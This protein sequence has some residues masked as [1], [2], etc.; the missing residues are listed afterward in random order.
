V[1]SMTPTPSRRTSQG[2][3]LSFELRLAG[4]ALPTDFRWA[5]H[6]SFGY[7]L[8]DSLVNLHHF[9]RGFFNQRTKNPGL[10]FTS[11]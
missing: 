8:P 4:G 1:L 10:L 5:Q 7:D 6:D 9:Q 11:P 2:R 3:W